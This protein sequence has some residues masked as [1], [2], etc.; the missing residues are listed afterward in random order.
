MAASLHAMPIERPRLGPRN[1]V[2]YALAGLRQAGV[3]ISKRLFK[4]TQVKFVSP[5]ACQLTMQHPVGVGD[6][7]DR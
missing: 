3:T 2:Y 6:R 4:W 7:I 1:H 5:G